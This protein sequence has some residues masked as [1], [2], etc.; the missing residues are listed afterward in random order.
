MRQERYE[1][2]DVI[3]I[4]G[5][6][7]G[8]MAA[9]RA[10][11]CGARVLLLEKNEEL[12]KKLLITGGGRCNLTNVGPDFLEKFGKDKK[13]LF[14]PFSR[15]GVEDTLRFFNER[16][17]PIKVE[18][19]GRV[20]P[21][22]DQAQSVWAALSRYMDEGRVEVRRNVFVK[23]FEAQSGCII[24]LRIGGNDEVLRA[25][26]YVLATG[27]LS[28]PETGSTGDGFR[29]LKELGHTVR[30]PEPSLVPIRVRE[31]WVHA[32]S[33]TAL[34]DAALSVYQDGK[35]IFIRRGKMLFT[36]FG[37][38]G[39]MVL[40]MSREA[41]ELMKRQQVELMLDLLPG[42]DQG[43]IDKRI[44]AI[45]LE[46]QNKRVKNIL[47]GIIPAVF[48][49]AVLALA[50]VDS[51]KPAHSV[52]REERLSIGRVIRRMPM[53]ISG[54]LGPEKA[55]ITSGGLVP[56]EVDFRSMCSKKYR[57]LYVV[58][59]ILDIDRPSGGFSL[60]LCWSTGFVAGE[61]AAQYAMSVQAV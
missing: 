44:Q 51:G 39:P 21:E 34:E 7:A 10:A 57:N 33:G 46:H 20:F 43:A 58:G 9:G 56:Y 27:G 54:F 26:S 61:S 14:S 11:E 42:T 13:F 30:D 3:V 59:D 19:L 40:N 16:K 24:G 32:L 5:G 15:F 29:F 12:G 35:K 22:S 18:A 41:K 53:T 4:G 48:S 2:Y 52:S 23:G 60:Q 55:I 36:H 47:S 50:G 37:L 38:S 6:S 31:R 28:H 45:F 49:E 1:E 17:V 25:S 8:M